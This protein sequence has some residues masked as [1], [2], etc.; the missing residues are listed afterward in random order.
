MSTTIPPVTW[1][2]RLRSLHSLGIIALLLSLCITPLLFWPPFLRTW[3]YSSLVTSKLF[4][5]GG[6]PLP[7]KRSS[8][9]RVWDWTHSHSNFIALSLLLAAAPLSLWFGL[10]LGT[11][12]SGRLEDKV[13]V[14]QLLTATLVGSVAVGVFLSFQLPRILRPRI[15]TCFLI[16]DP[17]LKKGVRFL[18]RYTSTH[19][20]TDQESGWIHLRITNVGTMYHARFTVSCELPFG[21]VVPPSGFPLGWNELAFSHRYTYRQAVHQIDFDPRDDPRDTG[22]GATSVY[23]FYVTPDQ[24]QSEAQSRLRVK[25]SCDQAGG[26]TVKDLKVVVVPQASRPETEDQDSR[27]V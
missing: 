1:R 4:A 14:V 9:L 20:V 11:L 3:L 24:S 5:L 16:P 22:P 12:W 15:H 21:W 13:N 7:G 17:S 23:S 8:G 10:N 27:P 18:E 6:I 25:I 19:Q 26:L 2:E